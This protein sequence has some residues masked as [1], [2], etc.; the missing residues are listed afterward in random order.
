MGGYGSGRPRKRTPVEECLILSVGRLQKLG[1]LTENTKG[2]GSLTWTNT[3]TGETTSSIMY[4]MDTGADPPFLSVQYKHSRT[5][6]S[7]DYQ[8]RL[9]VYPL[10]WGG[11]RWVFRCPDCDRG[12]RK[13][14]M[15]SGSLRFSCRLCYGLTY[16]S[17]QSAHRLDNLFADLWGL[18]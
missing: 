8:I 1:L 3:A 18:V 2:G 13:L 17:V 7:L 11:I 4:G 10:P 14:Y 9:K 16:Q 12:C 15:P 5:G 6:E